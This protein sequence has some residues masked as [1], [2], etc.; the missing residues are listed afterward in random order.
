MD[1]SHIYQELKTWQAAIGSLLGLMA[2]VVAAL[3][4]FGLNRRRDN[5]IRHEEMRS[6]AAA[7]YGEIL[8]L[9]Q[10]LAVFARTVSNVHIENGMKRNP[11]IKFDQD[12]V[13]DHVLS[14]PLV[15]HTL[16]SKLGL[17]SADLVVAITAFHSNLQRAKSGIPLLNSFIR[18]QF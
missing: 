4:N 3:V 9:R 5:Q 1:W 8:L 13:D 6:V 12:F 11:I 14:E 10:E 18:L 2:L 7:L 16:L 17:L 15:Y